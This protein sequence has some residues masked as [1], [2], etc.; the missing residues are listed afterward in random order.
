[1][2]FCRKIGLRKWNARWISDYHTV[3]AAGAKSNRER[4]GNQEYGN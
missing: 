2:Y 3:V 4:K 1:V